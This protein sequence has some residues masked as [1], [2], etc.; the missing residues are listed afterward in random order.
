M[1]NH[2]IYQQNVHKCKH[3]MGCQGD[4]EF[5]HTATIEWARGLRNECLETT[6]QI[7]EEEKISAVRP[8][9]KSLFIT[10]RLGKYSVIP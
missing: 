8:D 1:T 5:K 4:I 10:T 2:L 9:C 3:F 7:R 6:L